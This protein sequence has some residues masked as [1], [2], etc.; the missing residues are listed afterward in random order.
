MNVT[1]RAGSGA[2][3]GRRGFGQAADVLTRT[4]QVATNYKQDVHC[5]AADQP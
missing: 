2:G 5:G 1:I 3:R 4:A